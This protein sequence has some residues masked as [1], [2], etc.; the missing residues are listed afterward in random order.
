MIE[1]DGRLHERDAEVFENDRHR[2]NLLVVDGWTVLR[3]TW[4]MLV[5]T[6]GDVIALVRAALGRAR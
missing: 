3:F 1:I 6:P 2:Q 5:D 4:R